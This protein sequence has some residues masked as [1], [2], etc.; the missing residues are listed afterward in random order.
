MGA[1][2]ERELKL[3]QSRILHLKEEF[4]HVDNLS[5]FLPIAHLFPKEV[6]AQGAFPTVPGGVLIP[7]GVCYLLCSTTVHL[8]TCLW[9]LLALLAF[10]A[11]A[12]SQYGL[13]KA[14]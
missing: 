7:L 6:G 12:G 2:R 11:D 10:P 4:K 13:V 5:D 9:S 8:F 14:G 1:G 3:V